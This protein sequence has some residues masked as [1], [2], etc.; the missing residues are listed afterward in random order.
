MTASSG[1]PG[2]VIESP[3]SNILNIRN[4][5]KQAVGPDVLHLCC[6]ALIKKIK[7]LQISPHFSAPGAYTS[8]FV[9]S[10]CSIPCMVNYYETNKHVVV[11]NQ[12]SYI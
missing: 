3:F 11:L 5:L 8:Y 9:T 2:P 7:K 10:I 12:Y 1:F 6:K 4:I